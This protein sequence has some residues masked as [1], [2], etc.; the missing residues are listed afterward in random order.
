M[1]TSR[2]SS[3]GDLCGFGRLGERIFNLNPRVGDVVQPP[4]GIFLEAA[5]KQAQNARRSGGR[6]R[7]PI[8]LALQDGDQRVAHR[9]AGERLT[10]GEQLVKDAGE[11]P[12]VRALVEAFSAR[13]F[14]AHVRGKRLDKRTDIWSF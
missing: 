1:G 2:S 14:R 6:K 4:A 12:N 10:A 3:L 7:L 13:L 8:G 5:T 9:L 11:R